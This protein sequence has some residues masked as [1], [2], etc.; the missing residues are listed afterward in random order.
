MRQ[1][2]VIGITGGI[3]AGKSVVTEHLRS[4]GYTVIDADEVAREAVLPGEPALAA[5]ACAFGAEILRT[6]GTL[7]RAALAALAFADGSGTLKL[8]AILHADILERINVHLSN[9]KKREDAASLTFLSAPLL[10]ETSLDGLC[11]EVWLITAPEETRVAR[12][13]S[14]DG[15]PE[16]AIRDRASRQLDEDEKRRRAHVE[17]KNTGS[18]EELLERVEILLKRYR[19][20]YTK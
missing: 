2:M 8:N 19:S 12:A 14:R 16:D 7:D 3:G 9:R 4:R 6:D 15:L 5:L 20:W 17:I 18:K 10:F 1:K 11:D 13:A